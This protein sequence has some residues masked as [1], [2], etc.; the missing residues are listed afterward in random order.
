MQDLDLL[1]HFVIAASPDTL[2]DGDLIQITQEVPRMA[3]EVSVPMDCGLCFP[4]TVV[5]QHTHVMHV[6]LAVAAAH[7]RL[8]IGQ[9]NPS[10]EE[11]GHWNNAI[12]IFRDILNN[13]W[14]QQADAVLTTSMFLSMLSFVDGSVSH[15]KKSVVR[16]LDFSSFSWF[17]VQ[18]GIVELI[19]LASIRASSNVIM[20]YFEDV[21]PSLALLHDERSGTE[22]IPDH[23]VKLFDV[24]QDSTCDNHPYLRL[25]RRVC[26]M[27]NIPKTTENALKFMQF[28]QGVDK[29]F[30]ERLQRLDPRS[31][32]LF[33]CWLGFLCHVDRWWCKGRAE[34]EF[35]AV[36]AYLQKHHTSLMPYLTSVTAN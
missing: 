6:T 7:K 8:R 32:F 18:I 5:F 29:G 3:F 28:M 14:D 11:L 22:G 10:N 16:E 36:G 35:R 26:H 4:L 1:H 31:I 12:S 25:L 21:D 15:P 17:Q 20:P 23:L 13:D 24:T 30:V 34:N 2:Q 33:G 27:S 19:T 9:A